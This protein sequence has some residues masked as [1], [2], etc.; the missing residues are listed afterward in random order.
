MFL[1]RNLYH[2]SNITVKEHQC[3]TRDG[4]FGYQVSNSF[5]SL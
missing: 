4:G 3:H 2:K 1:G 5:I